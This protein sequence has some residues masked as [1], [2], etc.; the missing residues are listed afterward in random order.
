MLKIL[1]IL[2]LIAYTLLSLILIPRFKGRNFTEPFVIA[3]LILFTFIALSTEF[4]SSINSITFHG[5]STVWFIFIFICCVITK[6]SYV[7]WQNLNF[8]KRKKLSR[9]SKMIVGFILIILAATFA[10]AIIYPPNTY[11]SMTYHMTR[12]A[13]W[14]SNND[15]SFFPTANTRQNYQMPLAEYAIMHLQV[16]S[17]SDRY[18]NL[19]QW[20][21]F[22][23]IICLGQLIAAELGLDRR[24]QLISAFIAATLPMAILQASSTQ[25]D[26]VVS[27]FIMTFGLYM[28]RLRNSI[29]VSN[30]I[31]AAIA[32]GLALLTKGTAYVYCST[33]GIFLSIPVILNYKHNRK[34]LFKTIGGFT[35]V[36]FFAL[37]LNAGH[38]TRNYKLYGHPLSTEGKRYLNAEM[39]ISLLFLNLVKNGALHIGTPFNRINNFFEYAMQEALGAQL[40]NPDTTWQNYKFKIYYGRHED[41][42]GNF[43]HLFTALLCLIA[44][45]ILWWRGY[46]RMATWY[47]IG[48]MLSVVLYCW[49]LR[50]Q[51]WASRLHT[52]FFAL[53]SPLL[54]ITITAGKSVMGKRVGQ[55]FILC[56]FFTSLFFAF[57][58]KTRSI[59]S[60]NWFKYD[61]DT[62][63][64]IAKPEISDSYKKVVKIVKERKAQHVGLYM[65]GNDWEY[66]IWM[67]SSQDKNGKN[68]I[69]YRH[70]GVNNISNN[71]DKEFTLPP[72]LIA[73]KRLSNYEVRSHYVPLYTSNYIS[74]YKK[75]KI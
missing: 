23:I 29:S 31:L 43:F 66:P 59:V 42:A 27:S 58:N 48:T 6:L 61:R 63:Y 19:I 69:K 13:H 21:S 72:Y 4:L 36:I 70:I 12:V 11:D 44:L 3:Y 2:P 57:D 52:P 40:N 25:N 54:S 33:I 74:L 5:L 68:S 50:W 16:L 56:L 39:S 32:L 49:M 67:F 26:L 17:G 55:I 35:F 64:F 30:F 8:H 53:A 65:G 20:F 75:D 10:T 41:K 34:L 45:P 46:N 47:A 1:I 18:A 38:L 62:L 9:F 28:L 24:Q 60:L 51:P 73:T 14:I 7:E 15:I 71:I 37:A 22:A